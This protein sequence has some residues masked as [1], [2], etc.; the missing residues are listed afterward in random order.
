MEGVDAMYHSLNVAKFI[1]YC[2]VIKRKDITLGRLRILMYY[3]QMYWLFTKGNPCFSETMY[4]WDVAPTEPHMYWYFRKKYKHYCIPAEHGSNELLDAEAR[5]FILNFVEQ[6]WY[7]D[8]FQ[9][10]VIARRQMPWVKNYCNYDTR[11]IPMSDMRAFADE[12]RK[13]QQDEA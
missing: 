8:T 2:H 9:L 1:V 13:K 3:L 5:S 7:Y 12:L 4:A 6:I 10:E 11:E